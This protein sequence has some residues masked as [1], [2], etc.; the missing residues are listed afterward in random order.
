M[1]SL[2][3]G[4]SDAFCL[5]FMLSNMSWKRKALIRAEQEQHF[6]GCCLIFL[7]FE[8]L[9]DKEDLVTSEEKLRS[10]HSLQG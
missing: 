4:I 3:I 9:I 10:V 1:S 5:L 7:S 2:T 8:F 6:G